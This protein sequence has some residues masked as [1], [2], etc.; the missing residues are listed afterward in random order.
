MLPAEV[1]TILTNFAADIVPTVLA[2]VG[3]LVPVALTLFG[4]SFGVKKGLA[5]IQKRAKQTL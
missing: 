4:I 3:I 2:L 5:F 1:Q